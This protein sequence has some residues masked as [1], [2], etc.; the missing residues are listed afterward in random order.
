MSHDVGNEKLTAAS[1]L[2]PYKWDR[3][4]G[5]TEGIHNHNCRITQEMM[6]KLN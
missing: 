6:K 4:G 3:W 5:G 2:R 1:F